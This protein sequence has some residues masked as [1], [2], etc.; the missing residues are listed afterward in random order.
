MRSRS[1]VSVT[2]VLSSLVL[3][4]A[5]LAAYRS[6]LTLAAATASIVRTNET[7]LALERALSLLRDAE[8]GQRGYLLT[9]RTEYLA[10]YDQALAQTANELRELDRLV[11]GDTA[12]ERSLDELKALVQ[13][14]SDELARTIELQRNGA[15]TDALAAVL[16]DTGRFA[17]DEIRAITE[18]MQEDQDRKL[19]AQIE[20]ERSARTAAVR[21][22]VAL[23]GLAIAILVV[24][25]V[26]VRRDSARRRASEQ[27]LV[28]TLR[29]IGDAVITTDEKGIVS[30]INSVAEAL[31][32]WR[33]GESL[34][35][36]LDEVFRIINEESR[37]TVES[38]VARVL[39]DGRVSG[40]AN[41]TLLIRRDGKET[42]IEDSAAPIIDE[43]GGLLGVVLVFRDATETRAAEQTLRDADR[44]K[45]EFLA[46]LAHEL[47][48]PLAPIRQAAQIAHS[49]SATPAQIGW[50]YDVIERQV[51]HM[52]RLLDDLLDVSRITRGTLEVRRSRVELGS[53]IEAATE[54]ARPLIDARRHTLQLDVTGEP[55]PLDADPLRIAQVIGNLLTN[56][57]KYT[58]AGG[59][60]R[61][62]AERSG[63]FAAVRIVDN[64][65]GLSRESLS[66]IFQMF[67]QIASPLDRDEGGLG[68]GLAL[69]KGLVELHGG[70]VTASSP[71]AGKGSEFVVRLPLARE[72]ARATPAKLFAT[73]AQRESGLRILVADDNRD[74]AAS[75]AALLELEGHRVDVVNDGAAALSAIEKSRPHIALLDIGMP[76]VNG[77]DVAKRVR[78]SEWGERITLVAVTG[79]GQETDRDRA[80]AAGFDEHWVKPVE[81]SVALKLCNATAVRRTS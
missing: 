7:K 80:F 25:V 31:T 63:D 54:M 29:S 21:S 27:R 42:P 44:R 75:L 39:R 73:A 60:I 4:L 26:V 15:A 9:R 81:P 77:Y 32:G 71:G 30:L 69:S 45:N 19:G 28:T 78:A 20:A 51:G 24:L 56:A 50:S 48:N 66:N 10:P 23:T 49:A 36:H 17:M 35:K 11:A 33:S 18:R 16:T 6:N 41:H 8:I 62:S 38:P 13:V 14:K 76:N 3:L 46:V 79:W 1:I 58:P 74:A 68:I 12:A 67:V 72:P 34:G 57:A 61:L 40:L 52:A 43:E 59:R 22:L 55:L 70:T 53:V 37:A 47:R 5:G 65:V 64:G 2:L